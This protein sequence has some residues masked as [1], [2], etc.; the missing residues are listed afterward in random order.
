M[1]KFF[2]M[3]IKRFNDTEFAYGEQVELVTG[4]FEKCVDCGL[5]IGMRKWLPPLKAKLSKPF[6]G[7]FVYGTFTTFLASENFKQKYEN[8]C[9]NGIITFEPVEITKVVGKKTNSPIPPQY[10]YVTVINSKTRI[11]E[12]KSSFIRDGE[13]ECNTCRI[14]GTISSYKGIYIDQSTWDGEDI[15]YPIGL[16]GTLIVSQRFYEFVVNNNFLNIDL[17]PANEYEPSW[18]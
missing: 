18:L 6:Y 7:D 13:V 11:D 2:V 1:M 14:G 16:P 3:N 4:D 8:A 15:F 12:V 9:L 17:I 10:Y 5:P